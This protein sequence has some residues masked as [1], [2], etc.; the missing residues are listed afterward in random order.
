MPCRYNRRR[1]WANRI[2][3][4]AKTHGDA[5][6]VTLTYR[7]EVIPP[8]GTL[9]PKHTQNW[10]K[11]LRRGLETPLR[12]FL[13]GEYGDQSQRPH[14]HAA[15]FGHPGCLYG[16]DDYH[17][18]TC[19]CPPCERI[20]STWGLGLTDNA[21]LTLDSAQYIA[22]YVTKKLTSKSDPRLNGRY[23][24]FAR[25]SLKPGIGATAIPSIAEVLTSE[26]GVN[27]ILRDEDV[28]LAL[29]AGQKNLPLGRYLRRKLREQ[30]G[31]KETSTPQSVLLRL[32]QEKA[33]EIG[34]AL[35]NP[36]NKNKSVKKI[37]LELN[38]QKV[39]NLENRIKIFAKKGSL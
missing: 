31:H 30:L 36:Q 20:R 24:E 6:F 14:Y 17:R 38:K 8:G 3:L 27:T 37:L 34:E 10:L 4:E 28:P 32:Q 5:S 35:K 29:K 7:P 23:P 1:L 2:M 15:I 12:F 18:R 26:H 9:V 19:K 25:M 22:G 21:F 13:V 11:R 16:A 33:T 39:L